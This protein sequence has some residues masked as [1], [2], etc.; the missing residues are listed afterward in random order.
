MGKVIVSRGIGAPDFTVTDRYP[1]RNVVS[2]AIHQFTQELAKDESEQENIT[3]LVSSKI[4]IRNVAINSV[5][6][7]HFRL[8]FYS[9]DSF[10][11]SDL[12]VD[13]YIGAVELDVEKY[14]QLA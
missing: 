11:D 14:G 2:D 7:L 5:Q 12:D 6:A 9:K 8:E 3:G 4:L 13:T 10:T 1:S